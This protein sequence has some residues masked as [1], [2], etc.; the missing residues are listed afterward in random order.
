MAAPNVLGPERP[1]ASSVK[2]SN[3]ETAG[4]IAQP[5]AILL[6]HAQGTPPPIQKSDQIAMPYIAFI[7]HSIRYNEPYDTNPFPYQSSLLTVEGHTCF[8]IP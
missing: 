2:G 7:Y 3:R 4:Y 5:A 6:N 8:S 1:I